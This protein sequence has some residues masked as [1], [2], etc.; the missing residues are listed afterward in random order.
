MSD[1]FFALARARFRFFFS[2]S[3]FF[4]SFRVVVVV[5][6]LFPSHSICFQFLSVSVCVFSKIFQE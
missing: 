2:I 3:F 4:F 1:D 5:R 6:R